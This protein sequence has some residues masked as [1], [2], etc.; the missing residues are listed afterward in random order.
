MGERHNCTLV[1]NGA[2]VPQADV[3]PQT[4][5]CIREHNHTVKVSIHNRRVR[6]HPSFHQAASSTVAHSCRSHPWLAPPPPPPAL[7]TEEQC[8]WSSL[9][10]HGPAPS[11]CSAGQTHQRGS[12]LH[13]WHWSPASSQMGRIHS[14]SHCTDGRNGSIKSYCHGNEILLQ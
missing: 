5:V 4:L 12:P 13:W 6:P 11:R 9:P 1:Q 7:Q 3:Q 2:R 8:A 14:T 10:G